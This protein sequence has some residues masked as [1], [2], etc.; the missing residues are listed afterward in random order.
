MRQAGL[1]WQDEGS[2]VVFGSGHGVDVDVVL[3]KD[4][5]TSIR[6]LHRDSSY[7]ENSIDNKNERS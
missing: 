1:Q 2:N 3:N 6:L 7:P 5:L 4:R